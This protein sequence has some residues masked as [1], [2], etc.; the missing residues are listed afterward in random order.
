MRKRKLLRV[1]DIANIANSRNI[2]TRE[3]DVNMA[4]KDSIGKSAN[5]QILLQ[6]SRVQY[7]PLCP[8][9]TVVESVPLPVNATGESG[10][11]TRH[12]C[13]ARLRALA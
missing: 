8:R 12:I 6:V 2:Y 3:S 13:R 11:I 10:V 5:R 1:A 4:H 9:D 7:W